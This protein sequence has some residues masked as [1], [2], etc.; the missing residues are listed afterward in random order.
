M[1]DHFHLVAVSIK[2][3]KSIPQSGD[4]KNRIV[5]LHVAM[6]YSMAHSI[7]HGK[8]VCYPGYFEM[9]KDI[10]PGLTGGIIHFGFRLRSPHGIEE[11][12]KKIKAAGGKIKDQGEFIP[13]SPYVFF[14]DPNGYEVE[15]WYELLPQNG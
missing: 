7:Y 13:G 12:L 14:E 1:N 5:T 9:N 6:Y 8:G 11:I 15:V 2:D 10:T 4:I 3:I